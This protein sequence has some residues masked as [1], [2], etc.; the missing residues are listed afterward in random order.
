MLDVNAYVL[1][2]VNQELNNFC[3]DAQEGKLVA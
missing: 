3:K 2:R 1:L